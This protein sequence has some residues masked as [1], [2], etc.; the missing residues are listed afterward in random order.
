MKKLTKIVATI[1]DR[2]CD[3][4]FIRTLH[5]AG[6]NVVRINTAH[7]KPEDTL[8]VM[9]SV[10]KVSDKIAILIDTKGPE[11]R[12]T[13]PETEIQIKKGDRIIVKG[14]PEKISSKVCIYVTYP[15]FVKDLN[16]GSSILIDDGS[17]ELRVIEKNKDSL[18]CEAKNDG[19]FADKK[20]INLPGA[21]I[22]L[23]SL[24]KKDKDYVYFSIENNVDFIAHSFVRNKED[25][26][27]IQKILDEKKSKIKIIAKIE[28]QEGVDNIDEI[29]DYAYGVMIARGDMG[30]EIPAEKLPG[31]Q[32]MMI[33]KCVERRKPVIVAT[34]MLHTMM[35]NPRPT[36]AE[37]SDI[38]NAIYDGTDAIML[39]G[40]TA[41]GNYPVESVEMMTKVAR[42]VEAARAAYGDRPFTS[43]GHEEITSFLSKAAVIAS[44]Q[45]YAKVII[46]DTMTGRTAKH[47]SS[48][49]AKTPIYA[50][51]YDQRVMR[52]LALSYGVYPEFLPVEQ[53]IDGFIKKTI[54]SLIQKK[55]LQ[56][57]DLVVVLAGN[58]GPTH[59]P[60]FIEVSTVK[61]MMAR[62]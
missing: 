32:K 27:A 44:A 5:E 50:E 18:V 23:S 11:I 46:A 8:K 54:T 57:E 26:L 56:T 52:E 3:E 15:D 40:E 29:L 48:F 41:N 19:S 42:E 45:L 24:S 9:N 1:S 16:V 35:K 34:Q 14:D 22:N 36:R 33:R 7:Q 6:M 31:I 13:K 43:Q 21:K 20:S 2:K 39:S 17:I 49:R 53:N 28:N 37:V 60:S 12:T 59:G 47:L 4:S 55:R 30:V 62:K 38:A 25:V 51:C 10:R 61:N 58:F